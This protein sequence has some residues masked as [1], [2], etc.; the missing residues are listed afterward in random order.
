MADDAFVLHETLDV[1][2]GE[3]GDPIEVEGMKGGA[4]VLSLGQDGPP[5]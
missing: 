3:A 1:G 2:V 4:K 5:A